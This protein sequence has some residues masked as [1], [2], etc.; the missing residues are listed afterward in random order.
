MNIKTSDITGK[1]MSLS[2]FEDLD[3]IG[4]Y[5]AKVFL[6]GAAHYYGTEEISYYA[7]EGFKN[8]SEFESEKLHGF[9]QF[10]DLTVR[11]LKSASD[12][13][14]YAIRKYFNH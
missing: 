2:Y 6:H 11:Q 4:I 13:A 8:T 5:F 1:I 14:L 10:D 3:D 9:E 7:F 12:E